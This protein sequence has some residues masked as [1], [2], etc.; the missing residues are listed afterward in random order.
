MIRSGSRPSRCSCGTGNEAACKIQ[1][2]KSKSG[3]GEK[4]RHSEQ[5]RAASTAAAFVMVARRRLMRCGAH[6]VM[7]H[8]RR[9]VDVRGAAWLMDR[10]MII[11]H[12]AVHKLIAVSKGKSGR[13]CQDAK[14]VQRSDNE[15]R[16]VARIFCEPQQHRG[17]GDQSGLQGITPSISEG[18]CNQLLSCCVCASSTMRA[19]ASC[20][21]TAG[22][23]RTRLLLQGSIVEQ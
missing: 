16:H 3:C 15:R 2:A 12:Q 6:E 9:R 22:I 19:R 11:L 7:M 10:R 13:R 8:H 21:E 1:V 18:H 23:S 20:V 17:R 5:R 4:G 14:R